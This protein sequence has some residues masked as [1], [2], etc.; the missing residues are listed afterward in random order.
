MKSNTVLCVG[1]ARLPEGMTA[2]V[3]FKIFGVGLEVDLQSKI[4]IRAQTTSDTGLGDDFLV[5][6]F[7]NKNI[8]AEMKDILDEINRRYRGHG[9][10]AI[11]AA[12]KRAYAEYLN[13]KE[14]KEVVEGSSGV[15]PICV[16]SKSAGACR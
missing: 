3:I 14:E 16:L 15:V 13:Y 4:I 2:E 5:S 8:E 7:I 1:Y 10:K 6:I 9:S 12:T 11:V